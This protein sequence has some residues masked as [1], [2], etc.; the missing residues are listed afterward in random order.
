MKRK[1]LSVE[2]HV[3][4]QNWLVVSILGIKKKFHYFS[5]REEL[6]AAMKKLEKRSAELHVYRIRHDFIEAWEC[7]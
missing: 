1:K 6:R 2:P 5:N 4:I 7:E 3:R